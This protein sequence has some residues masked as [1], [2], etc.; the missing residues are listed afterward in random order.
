MY[1][2]SRP[3]SEE[4]GLFTL[5]VNAYGVTGERLWTHRFPGFSCGLHT[6]SGDHTPRI[7][8]GPDGEVVVA[9]P[10]AGS[11]DLGSMRVT[12]VGENFVDGGWSK[13]IGDDLLVIQFDSA[14]TIVYAVRVGSAASTTLDDLAESPSGQVAISGSVMDDLEVND[15]TLLRTH[16]ER[17]FLVELD[18]KGEPVFGH[19]LDR[20]QASV[21]LSLAFAPDGNLLVGGDAG[22]V[23]VDLGQG[24]LTGP[25]VARYTAAGGLISA[26][27][28]RLQPGGERPPSW[29]ARTDDPELHQFSSMLHEH[30]RPH[31]GGRLFDIDMEGRWLRD[32]RSVLTVVDEKGTVAFTGDT[33]G[34]ATRTVT[35]AVC[36]DGAGNIVKASSVDDSP[37]GFLEKLGPGG[38]PGSCQG[39]FDCVFHGTCT[40]VG[41]RCLARSDEDC[42]RSRGC[43]REGL[44]SA[45]DGAC[46]TRSEADCVSSDK[47]LADGECSLGPGAKCVR[48]DAGC[49][50]S[51]GCATSGQCS[52]VLD[53]CV[54]ASDADLSCLDG[55][56]D[57]GSLQT[58]YRSQ[59]QPESVHRQLRQG[60]RQL[61]CLQAVRAVRLRRAGG[62]M[63]GSLGRRLCRLGGVPCAREVLQ[64]LGRLRGD[65]RERMR[66]IARLQRSGPL[67]LPR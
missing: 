20:T 47:C 17:T 43:K 59:H 51:K 4:T 61:G 26:T 8:A 29:S 21:H 63:R 2:V 16:D 40:L 66:R 34:G 46:V 15:A 13:F 65:E 19:L 10:F 52:L 1:S 45:V 44:C 64:G 55:L 49:K 41:D 6:I 57:P 18:S 23:G 67:R 7:V 38:S 42:H 50:K 39:N 5:A 9:V 24:L 28:V 58:R 3:E 22:S 12:S 53:A 48:S 25:F 56:P 60:L 62:R 33:F 11:L 31:L 14:G 37:N 35:D 36:F 54:T 32:D 27:G 30:E